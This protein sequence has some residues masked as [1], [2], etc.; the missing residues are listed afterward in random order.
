MN[1]YEVL[2]NLV[3]SPLVPLFYRELRD[4]YMQTD[5]PNE[6]AAFDH[7]LE[8]KFGKKDDSIDNSS[9]DSEQRRNDKTNFG[10]NP[11]TPS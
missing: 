6:A 5:K 11:P 3:E 4:Y 9:D 8:H 10:I 2:F 1:L 7:L